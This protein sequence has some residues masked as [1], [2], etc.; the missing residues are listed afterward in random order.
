MFKNTS[1][2]HILYL[3]RVKRIIVR[4]RY[5]ILS[6]IPLFSKPTQPGPQVLAHSGFDAPGILPEAGQ[7]GLGFAPVV[8]V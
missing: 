6:G 8:A 3:G 4:L 7:A 2:A 1:V 5:L